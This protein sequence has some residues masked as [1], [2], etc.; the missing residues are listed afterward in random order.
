VEDSLLDAAL[1]PVHGRSYRPAP[2]ARATAATP[3][4]SGAAAAR[5]TTSRFAVRR[6]V[7]R[8]AEGVDS[9]RVGPWWPLDALALGW[10]MSPRTLRTLNPQLREHTGATPRWVYVPAGAHTPPL[11]TIPP[12]PATGTR[13]TTPIALRE[14]HRG[15]G[16]PLHY[17]RAWHGTSSNYL[18]AGT[19]MRLPAGVPLRLRPDAPRWEG[20][21]PPRPLAALPKPPR[22]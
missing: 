11:A 10:G 22:P 13:L 12:A 17:L 5:G 21:A 19:A 3:S 8:P 9:V 2:V 4:R 1:Q 16:I 7:R 18:P 15:T 6:A 20:L 14:L